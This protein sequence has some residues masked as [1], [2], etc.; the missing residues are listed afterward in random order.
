[1]TAI[2]K[3]EFKAF[4]QSM[5]GYI[6]IAANLLLVG[7]YFMAYNLVNCYPVLSYTLSGS[8]FVLFIT[9]P[10]LTMRILSE[11]RKNKTDQLI[12]TS[13]VSVGKIVLGKYLA[14]S[15]V[16]LMVS[17]IVST[18]P[19]IMSMFG[20]VPFKETYT[21][22][23]GFVLYGLTG[24]AVGV[25]IS[26]ITESQIIAAVLS[27]AILFL[28]YQISGLCS[29]ISSTG[30]FLTKVLGYLDFYK[31]FSAFLQGS[32][33]LGAV[34]YFASVIFLMLFFTTQSIQKRRYSVS[35][36][37]FSMTAFSTTAI[38]FAIAITI[39]V[40]I[41]VG[42]LPDKYTVFDM[43]DNKLFTITEDTKEV[44]KSLDSKVDIYVY[45]TEESYDTNTIEL[46]KRYEAE[47]KNISVSYIDPYTN[48]QFYL[49][50]T[51][52]AP[53]AGSI[54]VVS[55]KLSRIVE[56]ADLYATEYSM[57][58]NTYSY[59]TIVTG[60]DAEGQLTSAIAFVTGENNP[61]VYYSSGHGESA[62]DTSFESLIAKSNATIDSIVLLNVDSVPDD[63][64]LLI[65]NAPETDFSSDDIEKLQAFLEKGG[66]VFFNFAL[67]DESLSNLYS[68]AHSYGLDMTQEVVIEKEQEYFYSNPMYLL[69]KI[70]Y[71]T[72]TTD[73]YDQYY[74]FAPYSI[75]VKETADS[76]SVAVTILAQTTDNAFAK[77]IVG[78]LTTY[79]KEE[80]DTDGPFAILS[81]AVKSYGET[82]G[83]VYIGAC[84]SMFT[85]SADQL[86]S[87]GNG[88]LFTSI[89]SDSFN[90]ELNVSIPSK[91]MDINYL[92]LSQSDINIWRFI[93]V[94]LLPLGF[95]TL[96]F[97]VWFRR[98]KM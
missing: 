50:Y 89:L 77:S 87:G 10:I 96:G 18:Y 60:Y 48:P 85:D 91:S 64:K 19:L 65:I 76:D 69:P 11:D 16:F 2:F 31:Y 41:V 97:T 12:L 45:S 84:A 73:Y 72:L 43:T 55:D 59:N 52:T 66:K 24:I 46:L 25:F 74:C 40:N 7:I 68:F 53:G 20:S 6:F 71:S 1:M 34:V 86:V 47:T 82:D 38:I 93:T 33:D 57:D 3:R 49:A 14:V 30:N 78:E 95:V 51:D 67:T 4:F 15:L 94:V 90:L 56:Y 75:A 23:L 36:R 81:K 63:C 5:I 13:P 17:A 28:T 22:I 88:K 8:I 42:T 9:I 54:F 83:T 32:L 29:L 62:L 27:F 26:S 58:Y 92:V 80:G 98:R 39:G 70:N 35:V 21:V 37:N 44:L 79:D 61:K